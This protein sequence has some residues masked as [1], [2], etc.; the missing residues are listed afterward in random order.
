MANKTI[1]QSKL[2][3][4]NILWVALYAIPKMDH[5]VSEKQAQDH[6]ELHKIYM[7]SKFVISFQ[8]HLSGI[9]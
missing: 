3:V 4:R 1:S 9:L 6:G 5:L 8:M 2:E 7:Q